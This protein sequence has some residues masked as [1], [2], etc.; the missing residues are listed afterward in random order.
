MSRT[1]RTAPITLALT[2]CLLTGA[3][4][5]PP[6]TP[7]PTTSPAPATATVTRES[8]I[9]VNVTAPRALAGLVV[10]VDV[11]AGAAY[12]HG[13]ARLN[14]QAA[15]DP[16]TGPGGRLYW[17]LPGGT[18]GALSFRLV[19]DAALPELARPAL[20]AVLADGQTRVLQ[21]SVD[22][23]D[24]RAARAPLPQENPG[25]IRL[26]LDGTAFRERG[27]VTVVVEGQGDQP[28][29]PRL[30]GQV[31]PAE[32]IGLR[33][34]DARTGTQ[35]L[36]F[37]GVPLQ[38]GVN[39]FTLGADVVRVTYAGTP[40][41]VDVDDS[42]LVAD[43]HT[44]LRVRLR[45]VDANGLRTSQPFVTVRVTNDNG[46]RVIDPVTSD[47]DPGQPGFQVR[48]EGGE[49]LLELPPQATP[50]RLALTIINGDTTTR[51]ALV[52]RPD[53]S[54]VGVGQ[55]SVTASV[56]PFGITDARA[57]GHYEAPVGNG[58]LY[59]SGDTR[60][61]P[62]ADNTRGLVY[63]DASRELP[64][65]QGIDPIAFRYVH[66]DFQIAYQQERV[67]FDVLPVSVAP[68]ALT[69]T[70][71]SALTVNAFGALIPTDQVR[72]TLTPDGTR[73]ARLSR[74]PVAPGSETVT[75][76]T[77]EDGRVVRRTV[78]HAWV[79]YALDP[80]T[81][82]L[83][84]PA[85]VLPTDEH[86][87]LVRI[88]VTYRTQDA[89]GN[90]APAWG[91]QLK[92]AYGPLNVSAGAINLGRG[93]TVAAR[94]QYDDGT[95]RAGVTVAY[96]G[97][98]LVTADAGVRT[99]ST[100][101]AFSVHYQAP[102]Y[103]G[104][105]AGDAGFLARG[106]VTR[107]LPGP[108]GVRA[109]AEYRFT[110]ASAAH[111]TAFLT[112]RQAPWTGALGVRVDAKD[113]FGA[114]AVASVAYLEG[115]FAVDVTH[116]QPLAGGALL[117]SV[118]ARAA[119]TAEAALVLR[120]RTNWAGDTRLN[121]GTEA[122]Y[123]RT[124]LAATYEWPGTGPSALLKFAAM[125]TVNLTN[126]FSVTLAGS[127]TAD[128]A[129]LTPQETGSVTLKYQAGTFG[130]TAG[131]DAALAH[132]VLKTVWKGGVS[133]VLW[134]RVTLNADL[135][136]ERGPQAGDRFTLSGAWRDGPW[137]ALAVLRYQEG[138]LAPG[139][140][141]VTLDSAAEYHQPTWSVR[142]GLN[143]R[144]LPG[145][146]DSLTLQP[147]LGATLYPGGQVGVGFTARALTQPATGSVAY[148]LAPELS[149]RLMPG[150]W[151]TVG[152]NL[153]GWNG[154]GVNTRPGAYV[155]FDLILDESARGR[156]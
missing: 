124:T 35:R 145:D 54:T 93:T 12:R 102:A 33:S 99:A 148:A 56:S 117:T 146:P 143:A 51:H 114:S 25:G 48:L 22:T 57:A 11:P 142:T 9:V 63:G 5:Q 140:A 50:S 37:V 116:A 107:A 15:P 16:A 83:T 31:I 62:R 153:G 61:L 20:M 47:A 79:D 101:A 139:A 23:S 10:A 131:V 120:A 86:L 44:P 121:V 53:A 17:T 104:V 132:G 126:E 2:A 30:N 95:A 92:R 65:L 144:Y 58:K 6:T 111:G 3:H 119:L 43:G 39:T 155:R 136:S 154:L 41:R 135:L 1:P 156:R 110:D 100:N 72:E 133:G 7:L 60:G 49:G 36:E 105:A 74:G 73:L 138:S 38:A 147:M 29:E 8:T 81:G 27:K 64:A 128:T 118:T 28:L 80:V 97:G 88:E 112:Y 130:V 75:L 34:F 151:V 42:G 125:T 59:V 108:W 127:V 87:N 98:V 71:G 32:L 14:G 150:A 113:T 66:P 69:F 123:G 55:V 46:D 24:H 129:T 4:A 91:V 78:L 137:N 141:Q 115:P 67:P 85:P 40:V 45:S 18:Q 106:Q 152:Y 149:A 89:A 21:G 82:T 96:A 94:A 122:Q 134:D 103:V 26:P 52:V 19:H 90:R 76:V 68:T 109:E 77:S 70:A 84:F 13:S